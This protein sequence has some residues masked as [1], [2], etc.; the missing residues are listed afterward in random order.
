MSFMEGCAEFIFAE[1]L[2]HHCHSKS[3]LSY[4]CMHYTGNN[5]I[6]LTI[7]LFYLLRMSASTI[8]SYIGLNYISATSASAVI[9]LVPVLTFFLAVLF[10]ME[11]LNLKRSHGVVKVSGLVLCSVGVTVLALYQGP[12]L[13]SFI[14]HRLFHYTSHVGTNSARKWILGVIL[15]SFAAAMWALW[16]VLQ[17]HLFGEYPSK[18]L[19]TT[20]Q[21]VFATVQSFLMALL[22]ERDFSRWKLSLDV[23]LV[24]IIYCGITLAVLCYLQVWLVDMRG[25]VF[26]SMTV[27]LTLVFT[28]ILTILVGEAVTLG[29]VISGALLV[30][31]LY[32]VLWGKRIEQV[33]MCAQGDDDINAALDLEEQGTAASVLKTQ[34]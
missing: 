10:R 20:L 9:N 8:I 30:G 16:A 19:N 27:P 22:I 25:P 6:S 29:S 17:G 5:A 4:L 34:D 14:H 24:A 23:G 31:G 3:L 12:E 1:K 15:Q 21:I 18:L 28:I 26:L 11:S 2:P 7:F 13:K 33:A 32:N